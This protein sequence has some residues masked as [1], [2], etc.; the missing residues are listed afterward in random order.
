MGV[1]FIYGNLIEALPVRSRQKYYQYR[2]DGNQYGQVFE[3]FSAIFRKRNGS[4]FRQDLFADYV[5]K[6]IYASEHVLMELLEYD[7]I[8]FDVFDTLIFR[9]VR[10]PTDIFYLLEKEQ[11]IPGLAKKRIRA[12]QRARDAKYMR[13]NTREVSIEDIYRELDI[14]GF[15]KYE[16]MHKEIEKELQNC[17]A[18]PVMK[19]IAQILAGKHKTIV[20]VSDMYLHGEQIRQM[21]RK[22]GYEEI[23]KIYSSCDYSAGKSDGR[24]FPDILQ[25]WNPGSLIH[26]GDNFNSDVY[27]QQFLKMRTLHYLKSGAMV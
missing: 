21:L 15:D 13:H 5:Q 4:S 12:E 18:N 1:R 8:S 6:K 25:E 22:S 19:K 26:I 10:K 14:D 17:Y 24:L 3:V 7:V 11:N 20:A 16:I 27:Q 23:L 9:K 2:Y